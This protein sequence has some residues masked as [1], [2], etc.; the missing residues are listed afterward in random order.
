[1]HKAACKAFQEAAEEEEDRLHVLP[2]IDPKAVS[3]PLPSSDTDKIY[4]TG[5]AAGLPRLTARY[6][7]GSVRDRLKHAQRSVRQSKLGEEDM[8]RVLRT[9]RKRQA[10]LDKPSDPN[11]YRTALGEMVNDLELWHILRFLFL[12]L[13]IPWLTLEE[14]QAYAAMSS[15][16]EEEGE[17]EEEEEGEGGHG[18]HAHHDCGR[19]GCGG[20]GEGHSHGTLTIPGQGRED[21]SDMPEL[22]W[23]G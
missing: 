23:L 11:A 14:G 6:F 17:E 16:E 1:V 5:E 22:T 2:P 8:K 7:V 20:G 12:H 4:L 13:P 15:R 18:D 10:V 3:R 21:R 9:L 19:V